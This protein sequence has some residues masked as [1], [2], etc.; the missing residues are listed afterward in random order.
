VNRQLSSPRFNLWP[1]SSWL[2]RTRRGFR[3]TLTVLLI[4]FVVFIWLSVF[5]VAMSYRESPYVIPLLLVWGMWL[6]VLS[7]FL[8]VLWKLY[9]ERILR[10]IVSLVLFM[11]IWIGW[12][13]RDMPQMTLAFAAIGSS[14]LCLLWILNQLPSWLFLLQIFCLAIGLFFYIFP[15]VPAGKANEF[16]R[17]FYDVMSQMLFHTISYTYGS[18]LVGSIL[19]AMVYLPRRMQWRRYFSP[20]ALP[21]KFFHPKV[22]K[23]GF[24]LIE[25]LIFIAMI[26]ILCAGFYPAWARWMHVQKDLADRV[27]IQEILDSEMNALMAAASLSPPAPDARA[28]PVSLS[29]FQSDLKLKGEYTVSATDTPGLVKL[30]VTITQV[31]GQPADRYYRLIGYRFERS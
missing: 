23:K 16:S 11:L 10:I 6:I 17:S 22:D 8:W 9:N 14:F 7:L 19:V 12:Y 2:S 25:L 28:L 29:D 30:S 5:N 3:V 27:Q 15:W 18:I 24:T 20:G 26:G 4:G 13:Y 21:K 1:F 31:T